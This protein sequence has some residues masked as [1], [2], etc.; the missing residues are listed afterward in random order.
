MPRKRKGGKS[1]AKNVNE[2]D[3]C[4]SSLMFESDFTDF[5]DFG[6]KRKRQR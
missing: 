4:V 3:A 5:A 6:F 1:K 2:K